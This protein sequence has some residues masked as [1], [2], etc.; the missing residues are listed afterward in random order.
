LN[1]CA[2]LMDGDL[3]GAVEASLTN[4][5]V[6]TYFLEYVNYDSVKA[7]AYEGGYDDEYLP[8]ETDDTCACTCEH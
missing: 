2:I 1:V 7:L 3:A 5:D 8:T 4:S 6:W